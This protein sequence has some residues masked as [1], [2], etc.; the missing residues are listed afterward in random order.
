MIYFVIINV[1]AF[2]MYA[3]DKYRAK[4]G[5]WRISE[6]SL[7]AIAFSGGFVGALFGMY[8][9]RHKTLHKKFVILV[10]LSMTFYVVLLGW[11][12]FF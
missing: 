7:L 5:K 2:A 10:P 12:L 9:L 11:F 6:F 3:I 8:I 4:N 1:V